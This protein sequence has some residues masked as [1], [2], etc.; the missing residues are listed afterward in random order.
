MLNA[1]TKLRVQIFGRFLSNMVMPNI[2]AFISWGFI[3]ALF[4]PSGWAPNEILAKLVK[5]MVTYLL[6]LLIGYQG[7]KIVAG[8]RGGVVGAIATMGVIVDSDN[9]MFIG[10][11]VAG[12][13]GGYVIDHLDRLL[14]GRVK[15]GFEMLVN[16]FSAGILGA[17]LAGLSM[18][19]VSPVAE[20]FSSML[21]NGVNLMLR[22]DLLPLTSLLVEPAKIFFLNNAINHGIFSPLGIQGSAESGQSIFFLIEANPGPGLGVLLAYMFFDKS[23]ARDT[24]P[25]AAIIHFL[26][27][28]HEVYFPY[29]L[30]MPQLL[31]A[32]IL[33]GATGIATL[34]FFHA[35]L[36]SPPSPGSFFAILFMTPKNSIIGVIASVVCASIVSFLVSSLIIRWANTA[37]EDGPVEQRQETL[38]IQS[39]QQAQNLQDDKKNHN[40][41]QL[42]LP[43]LLVVACDA[44]MGSS[45]MGA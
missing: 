30:M 15:S 33:G 37:A 5:P 40:V 14:A 10:A 6:P 4:I 29:V 43:I 23:T 13:L 22:Y 20:G 2:G 19:I 32:L 16:N 41:R 17:L 21:S 9:P 25:G 35:G 28:I 3:T 31:I 26:G 24:A 36:V 45:A 11:M 27:G 38:T 18:L 44:G 12:P 39:E 7:G 34:M 1:N 42:L 8:E